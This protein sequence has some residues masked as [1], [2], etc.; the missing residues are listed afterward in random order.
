MRLRKCEVEACGAIVMIVEMDGR[1]YP[2]N[3]RETDLVVAREDGSF[4]LVRGFQ[5]HGATCVDIGA[6]L[7]ERGAGLSGR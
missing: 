3:P 2:V 7:G 5:P 4:E 6:R 1:P